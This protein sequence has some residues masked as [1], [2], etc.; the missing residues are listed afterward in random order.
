MSLHAEYTSTEKIVRELAEKT[1]EMGTRMH[2]HVSET[3]FEYEKCKERHQG[4]TPIKYF[5]DCGLFNAKTTAA[6]CVWIEDE[7]IEILKYNN[8]TVASCPV[9]NLK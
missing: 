9:S 1:C 5:Y 8:V 6:H 2:V 4:R 7:D 3:K